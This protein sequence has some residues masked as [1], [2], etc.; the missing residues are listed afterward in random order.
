MQVG[1]NVAAYAVTYALRNTANVLVA[2]VNLANSRRKRNRVNRLNN[3]FRHICASARACVAVAVLAVAAGEYLYVAVAAEEY[4]LFRVRGYTADILRAG[5]GS[6]V[7]VEVKQEEESKIA[8]IKALVEV[9]RLNVNENIK[10]LC[11]A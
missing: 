1:N 8:G 7:N 2:I 10:Y 11:R 6:G 9:Y 3:A 4:N 5:M